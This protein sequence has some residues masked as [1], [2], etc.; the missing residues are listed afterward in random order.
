MFYHNELIN[1]CVLLLILF[2]SCLKDA[3]FKSIHISKIAVSSILSS[4]IHQRQ[5]GNQS[6]FLFCTFNL[7]FS[8]SKLT[9]VLYENN[10]CW[11]ESLF[12]QQY[13]STRKALSDFLVRLCDPSIVATSCIQH[14]TIESAWSRGC[15]GDTWLD[16]IS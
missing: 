7:F 10:S 12:L 13:D 2:C 5:H 8:F 11:I 15:N 14:S 3:A 6:C 4:L 16:M 9:R 1:W